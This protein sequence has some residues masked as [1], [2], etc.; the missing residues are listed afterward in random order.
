MKFVI[1][2][3]PC[4]TTFASA[5]TASS[6]NSNSVQRKES[7]KIYCKLDQNCLKIRLCPYNV[8][9]WFYSLEFTSNLFTQAQRNTYNNGKELANGGK[10]FCWQYE[11]QNPKNATKKNTLNFT[12]SRI[13]ISSI[14]LDPDPLKRINFFQSKDFIRFKIESNL[15]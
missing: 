1:F 12:V 6:G 3:V 8:Y 5:F 11:M 9:F 4:L 14:F 13:R 7:Y 15:I 10:I 2:R